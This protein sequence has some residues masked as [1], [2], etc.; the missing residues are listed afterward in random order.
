M[1]PTARS[2]RLHSAAGGSVFIFALMM[3]VALALVWS[4]YYGVHSLLATN[5]AKAATARA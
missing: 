4:I 2:P 5:G 3:L 1:L